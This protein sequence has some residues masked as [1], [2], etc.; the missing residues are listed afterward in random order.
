MEPS[1]KFWD[2]DEGLIGRLGLFHNKGGD[3]QASEL[4][5]CQAMPGSYPGCT[6]PHLCASMRAAPP[7]E[8]PS[9]RESPSARRALVQA[10]LSHA[11]FTLSSCGAV[12]CT[13]GIGRKELPIPHG[14]GK[15]SN[16][17]LLGFVGPSWVIWWPVSAAWL[18]SAGRISFLYLRAYLS[19]AWP[20]LRSSGNYQPLPR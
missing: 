11:V 18:C 2:N 1:S 12:T 19:E 7:P 3:R 14:T 17:R 16:V 9:S 4:P 20:L 5:G 15:A 13:T 6:D 10:I 8:T